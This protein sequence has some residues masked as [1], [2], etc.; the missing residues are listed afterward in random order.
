MMPLSRETLLPLMLI[1]LGSFPSRAELPGPVFTSGDR[2]TPLIELY[3]SEGCSSCPPAD[4][5]LSTLKADSGLWTDFVPVAFH[6]DYWDYIGWKDRFASPDW[7]ARQRRLASEGGAR[8][9]YTPGVFVDGQAWP[10][11]RSNRVIAGKYD[12]VGRLAVRVD[13]HEVGV[14]FDAADGSL[15]EPVVHIA[16]LGMGLGSEVRAGEN[17]GRTLHHDFVVLGVRSVPLSRDA[18]EFTG[19][20][21][22]PVPAETADG[23][24]LAAWISANGRAAPIQSVGGFLPSGD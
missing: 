22:L 21:T 4:R 2:Q 1:A 8:T 6:V 3:T 15:P 11:W 17:R 19:V 12:R 10:G 13:G 18:G 24:A 16:L 20:I 7:S 5:W 9:V 14:R 23:Y